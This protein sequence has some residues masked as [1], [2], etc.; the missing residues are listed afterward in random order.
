[1]YRAHGKVILL[2]EHAVV[3][4]HPA[5]AG[6][7]AD[8]VTVEATPGRGP[9]ARA[10]VGA[11]RSIRATGAATAAAGARLP[12]DARRAGAGRAG[13]V[14]LDAAASAVPTG[15]GPR[16]VGGDGGRGRRARWRGARPAATRC[17]PTAAMAS[18]TVIHGKPS[19]L[20][21]TVVVARRLRPLHARRRP[22]AAA[23]GAAACRWSSATPASERDTKG[24]V[25]RVAELLAERGD[26]VRERFAAIAAL[27]ARGARR[28]RARRRCG[29]L[30]AAM[31]EN[32]RHL[33][34][35]EVSC[36][37]IERM[38]AHRRATPARSAPSSPAA[39]AAA[40]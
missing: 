35:L 3:Y 1:M 15:A 21:H 19:G 9:A 37:E 13:P 10:G 2:G 27:V 6:A 24:R 18:E 38:C 31:N 23:R 12:R 16:L 39:A 17:S 11:S 28:R 5:L 22:R 14:D 29:E 36:P 8:G 4:G 33:E 32:Q 20:D 40:A 30:G 26:E 25:A 7:L 34:A